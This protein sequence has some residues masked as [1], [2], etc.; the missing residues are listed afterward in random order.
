ML[1]GKFSET[2][3]VSNENYK[4]LFLKHTAMKNIF[5]IFGV[6]VLGVALFL[7]F[8]SRTYEEKQGPERVA[9]S[10]KDATYVI[11]GRVVTLFD[12]YA[13]GEIDPGSTS[14]IK[15]RYF[16]NEVY[17]DLDGDGREDVAFLLTQDASGSGT[18]FYVV[19][20]LNTERGYIGSQGLFLGDR[21]AP[22]TTESGDG[23]TIIVN[24]ADR[25]EDEP[26]ST[27]PSI[28][29]SLRLKLDPENMQFGEVAEGFEG[30]AAID[31]P[32]LAAYFRHAMFD[33]ATAGGMIPI[34][35]FDAGLLMGAFPGLVPE[36]FNGVE[37]FEGVYSVKNNEIV[38]TRTHSQ[39]IS[40]AERTVS[41][42]G[43]STLLQN[44]VTRLNR[45]VRKDSDI[46]ALV[47]ELVHL[48][49]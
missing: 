18:F 37:A 40:S 1:D 6:I 45:E 25:A 29:K 7:T 46:N 38:F 30:E 5:I 43:Y 10:P 42:S 8:N 35:G 26:F 9:E 48:A 47:S 33:A 21:I 31:S 20:A 19:A 11:D 22:Q 23:M 24:Y 4:T 13:E 27:K 39:P 32:A 49:E 16:G 44:V 2:E 14:K 17:K 12:G 36:D 28:G 41:E 15:T 34:E 3:E